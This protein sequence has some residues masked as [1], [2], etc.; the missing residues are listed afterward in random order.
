MRRDCGPFRR[1]GLALACL[2]F[3]HVSNECPAADP[4]ATLMTYAQAKQLLS[5]HAKVIELGSGDT[6]IAIC[7][8]YQGR[9]M[10]STFAGD[11]GQSFG[12]INQA[13]I[14]A[15]KP[16]AHF[17]NYG[18]EDRLWLS[19]EG[20]QFS[21]WFA[22]GAKQDLDHWFTPPALNEG[23]FDVT[24]SD[25]NGCHLSRTMKLTNASSTQFDLEVHRD[26]SMLGLEQFGQIFGAAPQMIVSENQ[27]KFVGFESANTIINRGAAMK[28]ETGLV[29][30]WSM[31]QFA[32]GDQ[33]VIIA[34]FRPSLDKAL[35]PQIK[36]DYFGPVPPDRLMA[37]SG[38]FLF[39]G[40]GRF[41]SKIGLGQGVARSLA[42][43][44]DLQTGLLTLISYDVPEKPE[45]KLYLNNAWDL[46][47]KQPYV[48]D[49]FNSYNDGP[50]APGK[51]PLGPFY[52][53]ESLS[54]AEELTTGQS[55][56]HH[57]RTFHIVGD[58]DTLSVL[59]RAV[60]GVNL[61]E[62]RTAM[63]PK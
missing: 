39:R 5:Q 51:P 32:P 43:S 10:T 21:L 63:G 58:F 12:W 28:K 16:D 2:A 38:A 13:F 62:V 49:L 45:Q 36:S 55:L 53:L 40:D 18:G 60:M 50:P 15:G 23:A 27:L 57:Q 25:A 41:R 3:W 54:R 26:I 31:G 9:V 29:S 8:E 59:L 20:G 1:A 17:N 34:P 7:P 47:Q 24:S 46:P 42:G 35:T 30:I 11:T 37:I 14:T 19:P 6:R 48:G 33:L 22:P 4:A 61:S 52:E 44:I 56:V